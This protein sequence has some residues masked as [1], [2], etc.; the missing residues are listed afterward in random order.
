MQMKTFRKYIFYLALI[1]ISFGKSYSQQDTL[2]L[3]KCVNIALSKNPQIRIAEGNYD[4]SEASYTNTVSPLYPQLSFQSSWLKNGGT[5]L[6]GPISRPG[7]Y[8]NYAVGFQAQ[9]LLFDFG[10]SYSRVSAAENLTEASRQ[11]VVIAKQDLIL[12]TE[13]AYYNFLQTQ[14]IKVVADEILKQADE[15]L[16]QAKAFFEV[17]K[18]S[19]YDVMKAATDLANAKVNLI[20]ADNNVRLSRLQL[21]NVMNTKLKDDVAFQDN[22]GLKQDSMDL[23][24][25]INTA[26]NNRPEIISTKYLTDADKSLLTSAWT[27]NLPSIN[28]TAGYNW[29]SFAIS[30][31]F[32]N[33]WNLGVNFS[34]PLFQGFSLQAGIDQ[35]RAN[36]KSSEATYDALTQ[37]V[38]LDVEEQ[39]SSLTEAKERIVATDFLVKQSEETLK[40]AEGRYKEGVG[41]P[42]EITDARVALYNAKTSYIQS[43]YDY[44]VAY[45]KL[46]R[47]MGVIK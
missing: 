45:A 46:L 6:L 2:T 37:S 13:I 42:L 1:L 20:T 18:N 33:S 22:L 15:H 10:K 7:N 39:Y 29:K 43:L 40:L 24:N 11:E 5:F 16:R 23:N 3:S 8:E 21:E 32:Y 41:S 9:Q 12:S 19:Q 17:G 38:I 35:A 4:F 25:C 28:A 36:L 14:R 44:Q 47:A 30:A 27:A 26:I 31:P 34:L